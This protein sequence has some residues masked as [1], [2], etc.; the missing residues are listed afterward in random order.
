MR[1]WLL[2]GCVACADVEVHGGLQRGPPA[3]LVT[4]RA[5]PG[6]RATFEVRDVA[7][8]T[9]VW[10]VR[11]ASVGPGP[12]PPALGGA[13]LGVRQ[14][15]VLGTA[16]AGPGGLARVTLSV[17]GSAPVGARLL[18]QAA[19]S[20]GEVTGPAWVEVVDDALAAL[21]S[22][23]DDPADLAGWRLLSDEEGHGARHD[24]IE[25]VGG[26]LRVVPNAWDDPTLGD[27]GQ[28]PG[29]FQDRKGPLLFRELDGDFAVRARVTATTT[30]GGAP[31]SA[32]SSAGLLVR[33][34]DSF[35]PARAPDLGDERWIMYNLGFQD[36]RLATELKTTFPDGPDADA[37][38]QSSLFLD[39]VPVVSGE[40]VLCRVGDAVRA[41]RRIDGDFDWTPEAPSP[42]TVAFDG[43]GLGADPLTAGFDRPDLAGPVQV[44]FIVSRW[45]LGPGAGLVGLADAVQFGVPADLDDCLSAPVGGAP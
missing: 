35:D 45:E 20:A 39:P 41:W 19:T 12:C 13:C 28:G 43:A 24:V 15:S 4:P 7:P 2:V 22:E 18:V 5:V 38:S 8:G 33:G 27:G 44:G 32:F 40:V 16:V 6:H 31:Q 26:A 10:L 21:S 42:A 9:S 37:L 36:G 23:F 3:V 34:V 25:V 14:P 30:A 17:P 29:W 11:G 1:G